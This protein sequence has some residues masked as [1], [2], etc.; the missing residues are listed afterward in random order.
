MERLEEHR[1]LSIG[2]LVQQKTIGE[3]LHVGLRCGSKACVATSVVGRAY[4]SAT[5]LGDR[6]EAGFFLGHDD[7]DGAAP[8]AGLADAFGGGF[9][10]SAAGH[11][12]NDF[13]ELV[14]IDGAAAELEIDLDVL[15]D[16]A[17]FGQRI[18]HFG[19]GIDGFFEVLMVCEV[20]QS[21]HTSR[22]SAR[23]DG[24]QFF[25]LG[26]EFYDAM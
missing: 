3:G 24:D 26:A 9:G 8:F 18:D 21:L 14:F 13:D 19:R 6:S 11:G 25:A 4:R 2:H 22:R 17:R 7:A 16:G 23:A 20:S 1:G 10:A 12:Q 15:C 5:G